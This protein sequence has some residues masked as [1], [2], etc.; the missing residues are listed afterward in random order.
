M[1]YQSD[2]SG[3]RPKHVA[4]LADSL[5]L[6]RADALSLSLLEFTLVC[7]KDPLHLGSP[8]QG[9]GADSEAGGGDSAVLGGAPVVPP[10]LAGLDTQGDHQVG[11]SASDWLGEEDPGLSGMQSE[12]ASAARRD[13]H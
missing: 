4:R 9:C 11:L 12:H 8:L 5:S 3:R 13:R 6:S 1:C 10:G 7:T 2:L